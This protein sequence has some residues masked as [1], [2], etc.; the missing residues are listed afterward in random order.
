MFD[1]HKVNI[2]YNESHKIQM[3]E[4]EKTK[5]QNRTTATLQLRMRA[6][7]EARG[8][9]TFLFLWETWGWFPGSVLGISQPVD[10]TPSF[11]LHG[12]LCLCAGSLPTYL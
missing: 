12:Q 8:Y 7:E 6:K 5:K 9:R 3:K 11:D 2:V 10:W 4:I 1:K